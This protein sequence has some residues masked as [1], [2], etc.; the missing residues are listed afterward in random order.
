[1][2]PNSDSSRV[3]VILPKESEN[4]S[5]FWGV[6]SWLKIKQLIISAPFSFEKK[7]GSG[8]YPYGQGQ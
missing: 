1:M 2:L 7:L 6:F 4:V 3:A 8:Q 5:K